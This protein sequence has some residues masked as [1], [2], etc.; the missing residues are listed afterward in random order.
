[1]PADFYADLAWLPAPPADFRQRCRALAALSAATPSGACGRDARALASYA[2]NENQLARLSAAIG[3]LARSGADL[4]PLTPLKLGLVGN[5]TLDLIAPTLT[6][7]AA[8]HGVL[9]ELVQADFG[10]TLQEALDPASWI[11]R[12]QPDAVLLCIDYRALPDLAGP[13]GAADALEFVAALRDGFRRNSGA[14]SIVPTFA[15]PPESLFGSLDRTLGQSLRA[16]LDAVNRALVSDVAGSEDVL[17]DVATLAETVGLGAWYSP[18]QW[19][20]AKLPFCATY[21]PLYADHLGRLLGAMKGKA[22]RCLILDL[23]NTVWGGVIGDDG[24]D[25]I[26]VA[27]GDAVGEAF[28]EVQR[29]ALM[30]RDRGVVVAASSK[31]DDAV[32]R[33]PFRDHP[34]MLLKEEHFAVFQANWSDKATN[35][36]AIAEALS[37]GLESMV[38]VDDNPMERGLVREIL[39]EVAVP[40]LGED[41]ALYA[42][43]I[44]SAGYFE[45]I[46]FSEEDRRRAD[47]YQDN[48]RRVALKAQAGD[49]DAYLA[50]LRM[51]IIFAPFDATGRA[52]IVQLINKSNQFNLT[53]R[54]YGEAEIARLERDESAFTL[55]VRLVDAFG[56][57]G[58]ISVVICRPRDAATWEIDTWLMSCRVLGRRVENMVL[59]EIVEH[60]RARGIAR[61]VGLYRPT[62]RN[63]MV[64]DHYRKLGFTAVDTTVEGDEWLLSTD[65]EIAAAPMTVRRATPLAA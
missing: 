65:C 49:V 64:R 57:N 7:S 32:A 59:R 20:L 8:R 35:I 54:R 45:A 50:S 61:L 43:A 30:L 31:N 41:P 40:E 15:P 63:G 60:A 53:T 51:E 33:A 28:L 4:A 12:A 24:I 25:G 34:E 42:R 48:A 39:P 58:M 23:D 44:L 13:S 27:Q 46:A 47:F 62:E 29:T 1:L 18:E 37:L 6:A 55:Q 2:L 10:Q 56:D 26:R 17:F 19:N 16:T 21:V 14:V 5:G 36:K 38:F 52:R 3:E 11:N 9:L 22:R